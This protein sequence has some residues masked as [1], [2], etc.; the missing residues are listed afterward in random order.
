[1]NTAGATSTLKYYRADTHIHTCLSPCGQLEMG[2]RDIAQQSRRIGLDMIAVCDHN[3]A[4]N[5]GAVMRVGAGLGLV[6][7][8]GLEICSK[9]EIHV[10]ALF[11]TLHMAHRMQEFVYA[12]LPGEN[13]PDVWGEQI[14]AGE[15]NEVLAENRRLLIGATTLDLYDIVKQIHTY[16]GLCIASHV[17]RQAYSII[18]SLGFIPPDLAID[19]VEVSFRVPLFRAYETVDGINGY[20]CVTGSDAHFINDIGRV[21]FGLEIASPCF[22]E[23]SLALRGEAGR[24]VV[25]N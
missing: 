23:L 5:A 22:S 21:W 6:V 2:P 3:S 15:Q 19:G 16:G 25:A 10:V 17:D 14:V 8:P 9:E 7:L 18:G 20:P 4:E 1:M 12:H 11:E 24:R 13:K